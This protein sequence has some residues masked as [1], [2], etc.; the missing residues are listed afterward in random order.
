MRTCIY[1]TPRLASLGGF[2]RY[3]EAKARAARDELTYRIYVTDVLKMLCEGMAPDRRYADILLSK[4][5]AATAEEII[6]GLERGGIH[7]RSNDESA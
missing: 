5:E 2:V 4:E 3:L 6:A 7:M 1:E